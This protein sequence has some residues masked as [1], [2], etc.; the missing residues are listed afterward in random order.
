MH[1]HLQE[2]IL[3]FVKDPH[4]IPKV[5]SLTELELKAVTTQ[6]LTPEQG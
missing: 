3:K 4:K 2:E 5:L 1:E 6:A